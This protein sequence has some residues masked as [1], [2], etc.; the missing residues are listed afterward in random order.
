MN[1]EKGNASPFLD[2]PLCESQILSRSNYSF[3]FKFENNLSMNLFNS[4]V[5]SN[6][7]EQIS[8][9]SAYVNPPKAQQI[10]EISWAHSI[11]SPISHIKT[12]TYPEANEL[13][14]ALQKFKDWCLPPQPKQTTK[15][16]KARALTS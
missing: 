12:T 2:V 5:D 15:K 14:T 7:T 13:I 3:Q 11:L 8:S 10:D 6:Q 16:E 9:L 1:E 4:L